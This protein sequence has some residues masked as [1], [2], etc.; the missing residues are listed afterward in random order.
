M[1]VSTIIAES[2]KAFNDVSLFIGQISPEDFFYTPI[3]KKW[4]IAQHIQHLINSTRSSTVAFVVPRFLLRI[5]GGKPERQSMQYDNLVSIYRA[6]LHDGGK[7]TGRYIPRKIP[8]TIGKQ[9]I[10]KRWEMAVALYLNALQKNANSRT[11]NDY[12][13]KHPILGKIT[14]R[15]LVYFTIYH[16]HHH[17]NIINKGVHR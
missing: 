5:I 12:Q 8:G 1:S 2:K 17:L 6:K 10:L 15:E 14:L 16:T 13:V 4:S 7:A 3:E 9:E 11:L